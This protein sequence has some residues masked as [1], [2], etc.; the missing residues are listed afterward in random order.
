MSIVLASGMA[1][2]MFVMSYSASSVPAAG[3]RGSLEFVRLVRLHAAGVRR[4]IRRGL[5][6]DTGLIV[7]QGRNIFRDGGHRRI[8]RG[9]L[10]SNVCDRLWKAEW[11]GGWIPGSG[12]KVHSGK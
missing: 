9:D 4:K 6:D 7:E 2:A 5:K 11:R 12:G 10:A 3:R 1:G 8:E